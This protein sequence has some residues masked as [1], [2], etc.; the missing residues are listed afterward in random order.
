MSLN[1]IFPNRFTRRANRIARKHPSLTKEIR[2]LTEQLAQ[3]NKPGTRMQNV[4]AR[5][6]KVRLPNP[7]GQSGKSGGFRV[8]YYVG[9]DEIM[10]LAVCV[11]PKCDEV[12][13]AQI[14]TIL[15]DLE[16]A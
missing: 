3:G 14:R 9:T 12:E 16:L 5:V 10:L 13:S 6:F 15:R 1:V 4:G 2:K 11:K 8:A 7:S